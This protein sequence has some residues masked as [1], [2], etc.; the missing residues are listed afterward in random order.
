ML[1]QQSA[2]M[3]IALSRFFHLGHVEQKSDCQRSHCFSIF[4]SEVIVM[5]KHDASDISENILHLLSEE[6]RLHCV[7]LVLSEPQGPQQAVIT[8]GD[9]EKCKPCNLDRHCSSGTEG[10]TA[11]KITK[12][13]TKFHSERYYLSSCRFTH[14]RGKSLWWYNGF[15]NDRLVVE[16]N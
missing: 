5:L 12:Y 10:K 6:S 8:I 7:P 3:L 1:R 9:Q 13:F 11:G 14:R 4:L 2:C 15:T 16:R